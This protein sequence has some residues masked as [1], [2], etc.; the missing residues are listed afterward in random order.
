MERLAIQSWCFRGFKENG[1]VI[2]ALRECGVN[3]VELCAKHVDI[4]DPASFDK[5]VRLY[6]EAGIGIVAYGAFVF[7]DD[8]QAAAR[9]FEFADLAG[10]EAVT[11]MRTGG[12]LQTADRLAAEYGKRV[13]LHN[14]GRH[15]RYGALWEMEEALEATSPHVGVCLDSAWAIDSGLDPVEMARKFADRLYGVHV[16]DF[17]FDRAGRPEDAIVGQGNLDL[18][19]FLQ[20]LI[21]IDFDG[22][23]TLEYEGDVEDPL[24][25]T[26]KCVKIIR[27][28][29]DRLGAAG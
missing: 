22:Y 10:F 4:A 11:A 23:F 29:L 13:A 8:E 27:E 15:D 9:V 1:Q 12:G 20:T 7:S 24:P 6:R 26:K 2:D 21:D 18:E 19:R 16:K 14:H 17:V 5:V 3:K 28:T 25:S